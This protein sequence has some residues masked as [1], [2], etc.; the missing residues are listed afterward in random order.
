QAENKLWMQ[1]PAATYEPL[2]EKEVTTEL[3][4][5]ALHLNPIGDV[6]R[7]PVIGSTGNRFLLVQVASAQVLQNLQPDLESIATLS[8]QLHVIGFYVFA[9][10]SIKE[11]VLA[12]M[13]A[14]AYG[15]PEEAAT[16]T[17]A[18]PLACFLHD[19]LK[20]D[21]KTIQ[22]KQEMHAAAEK[23]TGTL[24]VNLI[25]QKEKLTEI[26]VGGEATVDKEAPLPPEFNK[27]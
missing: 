17:A 24:F 20:N 18:G 22:I 12:R 14:P 23:V 26:W 9:S 4:A 3:I 13:F 19:F 10:E 2:P 7:E 11:P 25:K 27:D 1:Q 15:I 16:G 5:S 6:A 21:Q 8:D